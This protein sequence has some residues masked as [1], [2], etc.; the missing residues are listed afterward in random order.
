MVVELSFLS[1]FLQ[2]PGV[3]IYDFK[4]LESFWLP[5]IFTKNV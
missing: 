5:Y 2:L 3:S 4:A 1:Q